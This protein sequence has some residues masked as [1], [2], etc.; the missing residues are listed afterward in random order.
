MNTNET[1]AT[2]RACEHC[3]GSME[4]KRPQAKHCG[5]RCRDR[6]RR[7]RGREA[8]KTTYTRKGYP[9]TVP[10]RQAHKPGDRFGSLVIVERLG[11]RNGSEWITAECEC[12]NVK[13]YSLSNLVNGVTK[14]CADRRHHT[15]PRHKGE[16]I[17]YDGAHGRVRGIKG[18]ASEYA[19]HRG[20]GRQAEQWAYSH[21]DH[22]E[23]RMTYGKEEGRPY[24]A[25]PEHYLATCRACHARFD[26]AHARTAGDSLSL[27]HVAFWTASTSAVEEVSA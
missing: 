25:N 9:K 1:T 19:C 23:Q 22:D 2:Q 5:D 15:D 3:G 8:G 27:A 20:C 7:Q 12:G 13:E 10:S 11:K 14:N 4:G 26:R 16:A 21:A 6:A 24:S 17:T 18:S